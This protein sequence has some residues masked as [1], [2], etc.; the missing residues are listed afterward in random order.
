MGLLN[1]Q[2]EA[3]P[4]EFRNLWNKTRHH[5]ECLFMRMG[6]FKRNI[7]DEVSPISCDSKELNSKDGKNEIH[8]IFEVLDG[9]VEKV[10]KTDS[11]KMEE[12]NEKLTETIA[13]EDNE[14]INKEKTKK[15][16]GGKYKDT[17]SQG[18]T[19]GTSRGRSKKIKRSKNKNSRKKRNSKIRRKS[20]S[21]LELN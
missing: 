1:E 20:T 7:H 14:N 5:T 2:F 21:G 12:Y 17:V 10:N 6:V 11:S 3:F 13:I 9:K 8:Y 19:D 18:Y 15:E 4:L 16:R